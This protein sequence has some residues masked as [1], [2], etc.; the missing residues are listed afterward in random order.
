MKKVETNTTIQELISC[1]DRERDAVVEGKFEVLSETV[2]TKEQLIQ[3]LSSL[4]ADGLHE[5]ISSLRDKMSENERL[6]LAAQTG[7]SQAGVRISQIREAIG[8]LKTY[9]GAG[10]VKSNP[11]AGPSVSVKA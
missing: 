11:T 10:K 3:A 8:Q 1:L 4:D 9:D 5:E 6:L 2:E 7:F